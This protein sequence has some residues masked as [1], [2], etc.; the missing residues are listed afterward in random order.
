MKISRKK[1][2]ILVILILVA[3]LGI[4]Q[5]GPRPQIIK[6]D[7]G[8]ILRQRVQEYWSY[9]VKGQLDKTYPYESPDYRSGVSLVGYI[10]KYGRLP[11]RYEGFEVVDLWT[12]GD[13]G[14][15][16]VNALCRYF[17]KEKTPVFQRQMEETWVKA[18]G[19]WYRSVLT[20]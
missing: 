6:E 12:S 5:C 20:K 10:T 14:H 18:E 8:A 7:D 9:K 17:L 13:E 3:A 2:I 4:T 19:Q 16:K 11:M 1:N 15:V